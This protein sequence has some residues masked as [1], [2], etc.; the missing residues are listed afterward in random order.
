[1][2]ILKK[3]DGWYWG[4]SGPYATKQKA[5]DV[6]RAAHAHGYKEE[7]EM[8]PSATAEFIATLLHSATITHFMHLQAEGEG[9]YAKHKAL[10]AYYDGIVDLVDNLA[11]SIQGAMGAI[12][13]PYPQMM[14]NSDAEPLDY[15]QGLQEYVK[16]KRLDLPQD[17]EIQ[18]EIDSIMTLLNSTAYKLERLR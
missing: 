3:P 6:G 15:I 9:S 2:P 17:S 18:N 13:K 4:H 8:T 12:I 16:A 14:A 11:E 7:A 1:M 5:V 10:G